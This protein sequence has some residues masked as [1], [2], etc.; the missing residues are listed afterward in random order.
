MKGLECDH[1]SFFLGLC[2]WRTEMLT[3]LETY[4]SIYWNKCKPWISLLRLYLA[5]AHI[6]IAVLDKKKI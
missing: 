2:D 4:L 3:T 5:I 6:Y 1:L